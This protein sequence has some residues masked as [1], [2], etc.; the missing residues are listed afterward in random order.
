[1]QDAKLRSTF[2]KRN[3]GLTLSSSDI[4]ALFVKDTVKKKLVEQRYESSFSENRN[5]FL[6]E[7]FVLYDLIGQ[8]WFLPKC[9]NSLFQ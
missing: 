6:Y 2:S 4:L 9:I 1:M 5:C 3:T 7:I 8:N